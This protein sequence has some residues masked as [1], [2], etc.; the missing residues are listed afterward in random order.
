MGIINSPHRVGKPF[1]KRFL[2]CDKEQF[3]DNFVRFKPK[4]SD[5]AIPEIARI[6]GEIVT[7]GYL[8]P[9]QVVPG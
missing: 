8:G 5:F 3:F 1:T 7:I 4:L 2:S 6:V 9:K